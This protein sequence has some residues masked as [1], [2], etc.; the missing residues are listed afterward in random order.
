MVMEAIHHPDNEDI[1]LDCNIEEYSSQDATNYET[2]HSHRFCRDNLDRIMEIIC[3]IQRRTGGR[4]CL[5][6][7]VG[8]GLVLLREKEVFSECIGMDLS[9][10]MA[11]QKKI[12]ESM[13]IKGSCYNLPFDSGEF[14]LVSAYSVLHHLSNISKFFDEA[15]RV[16]KKG[17]VLYTDGDINLHCMRLLSNYKK[18]LYHLGGGRYRQQYE[19]WRDRM[20]YRNQDEYHHMGLDYKILK[21]LLKGIGFRQVIFTP[22]FSVNPI[23]NRKIAFRMMRVVHSLFRLR[24]CFTHIQIIAIK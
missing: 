11:R 4:K 20:K 12:P 13:L 6:V 3:S 14:D 5:D 24:P 2:C 7:G 10:R 22:R 1:I 23:Y 19:Y 9:L 18:T 21:G 17:G 16:L 8:S 15:Y